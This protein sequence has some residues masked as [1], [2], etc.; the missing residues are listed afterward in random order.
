MVNRVVQTD[1]VKIN[2]DDAANCPNS[3]EL[4]QD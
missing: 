4:P 2:Q 1:Y 3:I